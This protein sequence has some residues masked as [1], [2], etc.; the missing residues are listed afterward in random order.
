MINIIET[1]LSIDN[2]GNIMHFH[3]RVVQADSWHNYCYAYRTYNGNP[4]IF[5][6]VSNLIGCSVEKIGL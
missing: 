2:E 4:I 3:S 6:S 5:K 1:N